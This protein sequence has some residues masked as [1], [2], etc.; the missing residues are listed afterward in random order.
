MVYQY[1]GLCFKNFKFAD[2]AF[3]FDW[4]GISWGKNQADKAGRKKM[5]FRHSHKHRF[6]MQHN[7]R[8]SRRSKLERRICP[9]LLSFHFNFSGN[10]AGGNIFEPFS[11]QKIAD[12]TKE[13]LHLRNDLF[14]FQFHWASC[15]RSAFRLHGRSFYFHFS[16]S[17]PLY[18]VDS[19]TF[20]FYQRKP[21]G[22]IQKAS[23]SSLHHRHF[24]RLHFDI[25]AVGCS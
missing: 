23:C 21:Q 9:G 14:K 2:N 17:N 16:D 24:R 13:C 11:F 1:H 22:R 20:P 4:S 6:A 19:R 15:C 12:G 7:Q 25:F 8:I 18:Y 10:S 5:P 3:S